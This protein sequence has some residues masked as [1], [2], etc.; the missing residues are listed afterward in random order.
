ML[1]YVYM[2]KN[3]FGK[4]IESILLFSIGKSTMMNWYVDKCCSYSIKEP[5]IKKNVL[6]SLRIGVIYMSCN[7]AHSLRE[8]KWK[9]FLQNR[10]SV[11]RVCLSI[12]ILTY[13]SNYLKFECQYKRQLSNVKQLSCPI[14]SCHP[15]K[16][17]K[18][19][20]RVY[21]WSL[22]LQP[23]RFQISSTTAM[24]NG[25]ESIHL[26]LRA[27]HGHL[28]SSSCSASSQWTLSGFL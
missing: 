18:E 9:Y 26:G 25:R 13:Y 27:V 12:I 14:L 19:W 23:R 8:K 5:Q 17:L 16:T 2:Y 1:P 15:K 22:Q 28:L 6:D 11:I 20:N 10:T 7:W 3:R 24:D 4:S 21:F